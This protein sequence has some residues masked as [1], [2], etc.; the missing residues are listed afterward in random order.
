MFN[1]IKITFNRITEFNKKDTNSIKKNHKNDIVV[2]SNNIESIT[3]TTK[4]ESLITNDEIKTF[5]E[6][7]GKK[8]L[9]KIT[10]KENA[11]IQ[12]KNKDISVKE[13]LYILDTINDN[14][15]ENE[16]SLSNENNK[17]KVRVCKRKKNEKR[18]YFFN[19]NYIFDMQNM[20]GKIGY[21]INLYK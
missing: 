4:E 21:Y 8:N 10:E 9:E 19:D 6:K 17:N 16:N 12:E 15:K 11:I 13:I 2:T 1:R 14:E 3:E 5:H 20:T 18:K 7:N